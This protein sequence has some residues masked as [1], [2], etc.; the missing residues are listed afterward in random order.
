MSGSGWFGHAHPDAAGLVVAYFSAEFGLTECIPNYAGGLGI[1]A[2][3]PPKCASD[4]GLPLV[5][6]GLIYRR[7]YFQQSLM[8]T[9][10]GRR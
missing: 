1:L 5:G 2:D 4:E 3:D 10:D 9:M 6:V 8:A 7:G